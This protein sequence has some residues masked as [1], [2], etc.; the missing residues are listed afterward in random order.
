MTFQTDYWAVVNAV[1]TA[2]ETLKVSEEHPTN[3]L[4]DVIIG[5]RTTVAEFPIGFVIPIRDP[6]TQETVAKNRHA[7]GVRVVIINQDPNP[8]TS[9]TTAI[10]IACDTYDAIIADRTF[11]G[12]CEYSF[13]QNF[14]PDYSIGDSK[15]LSWVV[16]EVSC[17]KLRSEA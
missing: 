10:S 17:H 2:V 16:I 6:I 3:P 12:I 5:Q 1:K 8:E 4:K 13:P 9:L 14:E 7:I 11:G 15:T